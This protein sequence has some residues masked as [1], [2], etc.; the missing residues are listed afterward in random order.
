MRNRP[1]CE[2]ENNPWFLCSPYSHNN[3]VPL[4]P[5]FPK[6]QSFFPLLSH[7]ARLLA[8]CQSQLFYIALNRLGRAEGLVLLCCR[9]STLRESYWTLGLRSLTK[10]LGEEETVALLEGDTLP[11]DI[12]L[13][14]HSLSCRMRI[15]IGLGVPGVLVV[16]REA[17]RVGGLGDLAVVDLLEGVEALARG[18]KSV[19]QMHGGGSFG[20]IE[21]FGVGIVGDLFVVVGIAC[22]LSFT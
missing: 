11:V 21:I 16:G 19:H 6:V 7:N 5:I 3:S 8:K 2:C 10:H 4:S 18:R 9:I 20:G 17:S 22:N 15:L 1:R 12:M 14:H 13:D